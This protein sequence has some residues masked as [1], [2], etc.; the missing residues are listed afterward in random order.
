MTFIN[1]E[2]YQLEIVD[3]QLQPVL[4]AHGDLQTVA[5]DRRLAASL[6]EP[7]V[8]VVDGDGIV[9]ARSS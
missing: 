5:G 4:D 3:G 8:F 2:P 9:T 6:T 7:W 1:V